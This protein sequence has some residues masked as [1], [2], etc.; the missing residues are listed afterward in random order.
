MT[1][2][3]FEITSYVFIIYLVTCYAVGGVSHPVVH[4]MTCPIPTV[5]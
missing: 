3:R 1:R 4:H 5:P 2:A